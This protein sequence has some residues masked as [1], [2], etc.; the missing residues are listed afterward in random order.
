M[1]QNSKKKSEQLQQAL[2][3]LNEIIQIPP[4]PHRAEIDASIQRFEFCIELFWKSLQ[5][6][7]LTD[8]GISVESPKKAFAQAYINELITNEEIWIAMINDRNLTVHTYNLE[9]ADEMYYRIQKYAPFLTQ[10]YATCFKN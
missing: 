4:G 5:E 9:L 6:K 3:R 2:Q 1:N 10:Q 8:H 7:L